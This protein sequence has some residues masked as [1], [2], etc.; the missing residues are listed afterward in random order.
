[1]EQ[2]LIKGLMSKF[3]LTPPWPEPRIET[4]RQM[5]TTVDRVMSQPDFVR[6]AIVGKYTGLSDA[7]LSVIRGCFI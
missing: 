1:M 3:R 7:Y 2:G 6:I 4:W 5:A